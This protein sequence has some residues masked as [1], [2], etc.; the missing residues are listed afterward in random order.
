MFDLLITNGTVITVDPQHAVHQPGYVA[1]T[2]D[3]IL[4]VGPMDE[5]PATTGLAARVIDASGHA[6]L[7]GLID[8]HGHAGHCLTKTLGEHLDHGW[9][10]MA[11]S[12]YHQFSDEEFWRAE[13]ALAALERLKFGVTT[14]V[15]M[16]G[17]TP[18]VDRLELL[19]AHFDGA[20][21]TG[22]RQV[23][24]IGS[25]N[26]PW[27]KKARVWSGMTYREYEIRPEDAFPQTEA[28]LK[29]RQGRHPRGYCYVMPSRIGAA[30]ENARELNIA[31]NREMR[32]LA[33]EYGV[34]IHSHAFGGDMSFVDAT[35][36]EVLRDDVSLSHCTGMRPEEWRI[37]ADRGVNVCHGP[38]TMSNIRVRS[39]VFEMLEAGVNVVIATDGTAPDRSF[40]LWRDMRIAQI[41]QR[42]HFHDGGLLPAGRVLEMC[43]IRPAR[44]LKLDHLIGSLEVGKKADVI[45]VD[46]EQPHLAPFG[47][48]PVQRLVYHA[49]GQD[50]SHVIV[51][52]QVLMEERQVRSLDQRRVLADATAAFELMLCRSGYRDR[53]DNPALYD[54]R[55]Y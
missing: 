47:I 29:R 52:G 27:P 51:D 7:P 19:D 11:E 34:P 20:L 36:P 26:P 54:L 15:S 22:I 18:R 9:E 2:A 3:R 6:V 42:A 39:P 16:L 38:S 8:A 31:Q 14:G 12:I 17:N 49:S 40:D 21:A 10:P 48:M 32:R 37:M 24:G 1:I 23:S 33:D 45:L 44:A 25:P 35:T 28:A 30:P 13:G 55:S 4:G 41:L 46:V 53:A 43:T 5:L 50:V